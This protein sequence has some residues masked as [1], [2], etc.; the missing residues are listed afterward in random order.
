M[1]KM[2]AL[3]KHMGQRTVSVLLI[4]SV[5]I[6]VLAFP[7]IICAQGD[8]SL[9]YADFDDMTVGQKPSGFECASVSGTVTVENISSRMCAYL[10]SGT[11]GDFAMMKKTFE[12][13]SKSVVK[14]QLDFSVPYAKSDGDTLLSLNNGTVSLFSL[15]TNGGN[16]SFCSD[17]KYT[18]LISNYTVNNWY[19]A[20]AVVDLVNH[21]ADVTVEGITKY[22]LDINSSEVCDSVY[23]YT[24]SSPGFCVDS[25]SVFRSADV[26]QKIVIDGPAKIFVPFAGM[27]SYEYKAILYNDI[28]QVVSDADIVWEVYIENENDIS[29][30]INDS[31]MNM[32]V[33][34]GAYCVQ[35]INIK[36][37]CADD[38]SLYAMM[39]VVLD[40]SVVSDVSIEGPHR[41]SNVSEN[42]YRVKMTGAG[43]DVIYCDSAYWTLD[44]DEDNPVAIDADTGEVKFYGTPKKDARVTIYAK[45]PYNEKTASL[46]VATVD[47]DTYYTDVYLENILKLSVDNLIEYCS[48]I[49]NGTPLLSDGIDLNT[50]K[51]LVWQADQTHSAVMSNFATQS[52][53]FAT[54]DAMSLLLDDEKYT[55][56]VDDIY[57]WYIDNGMSKTGM[58]Y[59]GGHAFIDLKTSQKYESV[60]NPDT[61]ELKDA[62]LYLAPFFRLDKQ[63]GKDL[64]MHTWLGHVID[65]NYLLTNRH[66]TYSKAQDVDNWYNTDAAEEIHDFIRTTE[67]PFR[68]TANDLIYIAGESYKQTGDTYALTWGKKILQNFYNLRDEK[69][70]I[71]PNIYATARGAANTLD[72]MTTIEP[73]GKWYTRTDLSAYTS[74]KYG[75]RFFNQY[76]EDLVAQGFYPESVLDEDDT[77]IC[78]GNLVQTYVL[79]YTTLTDIWF[80]ELIGADTEDGRYIT[81]MAVQ[82]FAGCVKYGWIKDSKLLRTI[83]TDGTDISDF[84]PNRNGYYGN[85]YNTGAK[86]GTTSF[87]DNYFYTACVAYRYAVKHGG[88]EEDA[89]ILKD[90]IIYALS[91]RYRLG[92]AGDNEIGDEGLALNYSTDISSPQVLLAMVDLYYATEKAEF[93]DAARVIGVNMC[94]S[95]Y[96]YGVLTNDTA[97]GNGPNQK[98]RLP[99]SGTNSTGYYA[100]A[101]LDAA[102][103]NMEYAVEKIIPSAGYLQENY[104]YENNAVVRIVAS[105]YYGVKNT[106]VFVEKIDFGLDS[107]ELKAGENLELKS[108]VYPDDAT[109]KKYNMWVGDP[110]VVSVDSDTMTVYGLKPGETDITCVSNDLKA[111]TTIKVIVR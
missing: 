47:S 2:S 29:Y 50:G 27:N 26:N 83:M 28:G 53:I 39:T 92:K 70:H 65:W 77:T 14:I 64:V 49:Y 71:Q 80:A 103:K 33:G 40:E 45:T 23:F 58:G 36:A 37:I 111:S 68:A 87:N 8:I 89:E 110:S 32:T 60:Q 18:T 21:K 75:D 84:V 5:L 73:F 98:P 107:L 88:L 86:M 62:F 95:N 76:A 105:D 4:F 20:S 79:P 101:Y 43:G 19:S 48:D 13:A 74:T 30:E 54:F 3:A 55:Q 15:E 1:R 81:E 69:T 52:S 82:N 61:H 102:T 7:Q 100:L 108:T 66:A 96:K 38:L 85:Y 78:E 106:S 12:Q 17:G 16:I 67:L 44:K 97:I 35:A 109:D 34:S 22:N 10:D 59:W 99:L 94:R 93:L 57:K 51:P 42:I 11:V 31:V 9:V 104:L 56:R 24:E 25:I 72:P 90:F 46:T 63:F 91:E 6:S 41:I